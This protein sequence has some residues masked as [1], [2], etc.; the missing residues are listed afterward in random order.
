MRNGE[1]IEEGMEYNTSENP[2]N[3]KLQNAV[4]VLTLQPG[5]D[6]NGAIFQCQATNPAAQQELLTTVMLSVLRE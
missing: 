1:A 2:D 6:D 3:P 4:S 5:K